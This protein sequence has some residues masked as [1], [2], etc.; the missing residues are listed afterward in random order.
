MP[1]E[2]IAVRNAKRSAN[3]ESFLIV[4]G[5]TARSTHWQQVLAA[6][7]S[8][9]GRAENLWPSVSTRWFLLARLASVRE[10][11]KKLLARSIDPSAQRKTDKQAGK[12]GSFRPVAEELLLSST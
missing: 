12:D 3:L 1:L 5:S 6:G 10:E 4:V 7:L 9:R 2:D 8:V 11:A